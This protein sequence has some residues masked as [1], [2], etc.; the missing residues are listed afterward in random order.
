MLI[1]INL[2]VTIDDN[3]DKMDELKIGS[4]HGRL[5]AVLSNNT[6]TMQWKAILPK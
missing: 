5:Y 4:L 1:F 6:Q 3:N 2:I